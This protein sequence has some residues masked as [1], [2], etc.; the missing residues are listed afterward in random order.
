MAGPAR[1][2]AA[3]GQPGRGPDGPR[4]AQLPGRR[5]GDVPRELLVA[6]YVAADVMCVT[7]LRDGMNL[8]AKE[9]VVSRP[10]DD[11]VLVLSEFAGV[12]NELDRAVLVNP[13]DIDGI[14]TA[15]QTALERPRADR[16]RRM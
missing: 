10:Q 15:L 3:R 16:R 11:G 9:Y 1:R 13:Y 7:P 4:R 14:V 6:Y 2:R 8:V 12:A 5:G